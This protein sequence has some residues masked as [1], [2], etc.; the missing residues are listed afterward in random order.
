V[1]NKAAEK[2]FET[3]PGE[4]KTSFRKALEEARE[5]KHPVIAA[6]YGQPLGRG[7]FKLKDDDEQGNIYRGVYCVR[8]K[9]A[10]YV[11]HAF[12]KKSKSGRADPRE[13]I[14][15]AMARA[16][17]AELQHELWKL[18]QVE[19]AKEHPSPKKKGSKR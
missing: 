6:P 10:V 16:K 1:W 12:K 19:K 11:M 9:E 14:N 3:F 15:T 4:V 18:E 17:W 13:E 7:H 5:G 2:D 8:Y